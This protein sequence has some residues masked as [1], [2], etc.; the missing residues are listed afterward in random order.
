MTNSANSPQSD[1]TTSSA[2]AAPP[3]AADFTTAIAFGWRVHQSQEAWTAKVDVKASI[4]L[5]LTGAVLV[6]IVAGNNKDGVLT[7][8]TGWRDIVLMLSVVLIFIALTLAGAAVYP[9]LGRVKDHK[10]RHLDNTIYFGHLRHWDPLQL[11]AKLHV[12]SPAEEAKQLAVQM[13]VM[14]EGNW[15]KH[16]CLQGALVAA[17][18]AAILLA[19]A[20]LWPR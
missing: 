14:S 17:A 15:R 5:A 11:A 13:K 7:T 16:R 3:P 10:A 19:I 4:V 8:L 1:T 20:T 12:M 18:A 2:A 9:I 6:A